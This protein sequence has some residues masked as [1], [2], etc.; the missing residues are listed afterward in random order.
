M[1]QDLPIRE[2]M[3]E[4]MGL[5]RNADYIKK[6]AQVVYQ[7]AELTANGMDPEDAII[8]TAGTLEQQMQPQLE[9]PATNPMDILNKM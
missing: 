7:Y 3:M 8:A 2:Y 6:V 9:Q 5:E 1:M 4:R